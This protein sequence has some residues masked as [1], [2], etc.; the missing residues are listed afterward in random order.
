[1]INGR[2]AGQAPVVFEGSGAAET[3]ADHFFALPIAV[4]VDLAVIFVVVVWETTII[5]QVCLSVSVLVC[6]SQKQLFIHL[7]CCKH[8]Y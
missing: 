7:Q 3:E 2:I 5:T 6:F 8:Y 1:M 4:E